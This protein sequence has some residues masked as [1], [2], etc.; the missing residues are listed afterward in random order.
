M[1][2]SSIWC[3]KRWVLKRGVVDKFFISFILILL[4]M[5]ESL[6]R[7]TAS[8]SYSLK[9]CVTSPEIPT[10]FNKLAPTLL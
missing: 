8:D 10:A 1:N 9:V 2:A 7:L 3:L 4:N 5:F 6:A